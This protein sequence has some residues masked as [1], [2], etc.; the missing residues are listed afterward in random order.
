MDIS[1]HYQFL[2]C[3]A[4]AGGREAETH[5]AV[6]RSRASVSDAMLKEMPGMDWYGA[7]LYTAPVRFGTWDA[8]LTVA[9]PA[10]GLPGLVGGY[11]YANAVA[12]AAMNRLTE[13]RA[14]LAQLDALIAGPPADLPAGQNT[15]PDVLAVRRHAVAA[16]I[17]RAVR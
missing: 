7:E 9:P 8:L 10:P 16:R 15:L 12:L 13:A 17:G 1:T 5:D 14:R 2:A 3:H 4:A 6:Q 11:L